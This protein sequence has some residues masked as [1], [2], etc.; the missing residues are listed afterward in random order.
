MKWVLKGIVAVFF[1]AFFYFVV[2]VMAG[3]FL[4]NKVL[5]QLA[6]IGGALFAGLVALFGKG[7]G[8][9]SGGHGAGGHNHDSGFSGGGG[10]F[11]GGSDGGF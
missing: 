6:A 8:G 10:G 11:D 1:A 3:L 9:G 5:A 7:G 2:S 4:E